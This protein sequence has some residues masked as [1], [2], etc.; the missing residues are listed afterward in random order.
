MQSREESIRARV[1]RHAQTLSEAVGAPPRIVCIGSKTSNDL[2][3]RQVDDSYDVRRIDFPDAV[4]EAVALAHRH[5]AALQA[6]LPRTLIFNTAT[7]FHAWQTLRPVAAVFMHAGGVVTD[8]FVRG[9]FS[10]VE[11]GWNGVLT[12]EGMFSLAAEW[13]GYFHPDGDY[14]ELGVFD[15]RTLSLAYHT[16]KNKVQRFFAFDSF[17][18]ISGAMKSEETWYENGSYF[19]NEQTFW[20]NM[21]VAGVEPERLVVIKGDFLEIFQDTQGII[22]QKNLRKC[23][24]AHIDC[25]IYMAAKAGLDFLTPLLQQGSILL[26]DEYHAHGATNSCGE[27]RALAEWLASNPHISVE[28]WHDYAVV[29]RSFLVHRA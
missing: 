8:A 19:C 27:R 6:D 7:D 22:K 18:G 26:F 10:H 29:G 14:L 4:E 25:D 9:I 16:M 5:L 3:L 13:A 20:H 11:G 23:A 24:V 17:A 28:R 2:F 21:R 1:T 12:Y 15:G